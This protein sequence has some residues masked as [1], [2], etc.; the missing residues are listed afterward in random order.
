MD[1]LYKIAESVEANYVCM[2]AKKAGM[3]E[4]VHYE[5]YL[6]ADFTQ[7]VSAPELSRIFMSCKVLIMMPADTNVNA[8]VP[9]E[10]MF[11]GQE[12]GTVLMD[13]AYVS[14]VESGN[15]VRRLVTASS[16]T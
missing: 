8:I 13:Q 4:Y 5:L 11:D 3:G 16:F 14:V 7:P 15:T 1:K 6:D 10:F 12:D 9:T 2:H